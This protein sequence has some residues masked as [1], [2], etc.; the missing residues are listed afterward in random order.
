MRVPQDIAG[1][2]ACAVRDVLWYKRSVVALLRDCEVPAGIV[3]EE[4][5][6]ADGGKTIPVVKQVLE[7]CASAG[8]SGTQ[9]VRKLLTKLYYWN[10]CHTIAADRKDA[11]VASLKAF[12]AGHDRFKAQ[13]DYQA[14]QKAQEKKMDAERHEQRAITALNHSKLH[15]FRDR[16]DAVAA[17]TDEAAR[18]R[19]LEP[20][21]DEVFAYYGEDSKGPIRRKGEQI[22]GCVKLD[23]HWHYVEIRWKNEKTNAA[24]ISVLRDRARNSFGGD[25]KALFISMNG[26]S[27]ECLDS[28]VNQGDE[29]VILMDGYDLRC[30]LNCDIALD[31]LLA[32]K[33]AALITDRIPFASAKEIMHARLQRKGL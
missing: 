21:L 3:A 15:K 24:D 25:T 10:D 1:L 18:G 8:D 30:V 32:E 22:D 12:R 19:A 9:A 6:Y 17:I 23:S 14:A 5:A 11:A 29:R 13:S 2:F 4:S 16:F 20:L 33:Q 31:V 27:Q 28:L 7:L 26:F